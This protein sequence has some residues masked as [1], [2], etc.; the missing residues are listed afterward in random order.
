V[1]V[2]SILRHIT[3]C[4]SKMHKSATNIN[5][6]CQQKCMSATNVNTQRE[7]HAEQCDQ[8]KHTVSA[9]CRIVRPK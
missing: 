1:L 7:Q 4:V 8:H 9:K 5:T 6:L 2:A 3:H